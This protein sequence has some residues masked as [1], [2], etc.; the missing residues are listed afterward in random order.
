[1]RKADNAPAPIDP[2]IR[3]LAES[4]KS[5][6]VF[7][8]ETLLD[9]GAVYFNPMICVSDEKSFEQIELVMQLLHSVIDSDDDIED[10]RPGLAI[11]LQTVWAA[12]QYQSNR[13]AAARQMEGGKP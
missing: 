5:N 9:N 6:D 11:L 7:A 3:R 8:V 12:V 4:I 10:I 13:L 1:M 2:A